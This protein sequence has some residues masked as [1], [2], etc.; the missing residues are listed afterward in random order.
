MYMPGRLLQSF[1]CDTEKQKAYAH[2]IINEKG[3]IY[4]CG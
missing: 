2:S 4:R 3:L 1:K